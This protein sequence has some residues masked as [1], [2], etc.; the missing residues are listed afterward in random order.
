MGDWAD[1]NPYTYTYTYTYTIHIYT[2]THACC[3]YH[4]VLLRLMAVASCLQ[5]WLCIRGVGVRFSASGVVCLPLHFIPGRPGICSCLAVQG[6]RLD[7]ASQ[8][9]FPNQKSP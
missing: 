4:G 9:S 6:Y 3:L 2:H 8:D 5:L 7:T 1:L